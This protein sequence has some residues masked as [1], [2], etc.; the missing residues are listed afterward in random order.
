MHFRPLVISCATSER[1]PELGRI[2]GRARDLVTFRG[3][4]CRKRG[5]KKSAC[6]SSP[7]TQNCSWLSSLGSSSL[8]PLCG[9]RKSL[10]FRIW[11]EE[12]RECAQTQLPSIV[13]PRDR[14]TQSWNTFTQTWDVL[15]W[16]LLPLALPALLDIDWDSSTSTNYQHYLFI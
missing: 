11:N 4:N 9:G 6:P 3:G 10:C 2:N 13:V 16:I 12:R 15:F 1:S 5:V 8:V 14:V 7:K